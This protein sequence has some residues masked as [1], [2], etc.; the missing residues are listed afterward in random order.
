MEAAVKKDS[1]TAEKKNNQQI[2]KKK[3]LCND[4]IFK[5]LIVHLSSS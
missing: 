5:Q 2:N 4:Y 3:I 1:N